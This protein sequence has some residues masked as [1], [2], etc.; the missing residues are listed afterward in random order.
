MASANGQD[1]GRAGR[2]P[3]V[4]A[5]GRRVPRAA[6]GDDAGPSADGGRHR[7]PRARRGGPGPVPRR[8][9]R[10]VGRGG[11]EEGGQVP[12]DRDDQR[13]GQRCGEPAEA[14]DG[15]WE[16]GAAVKAVCSK[17]PVKRK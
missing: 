13:L 3:R 12:L 5:G 1:G 2:A 10:G 8:P 7:Q 16:N 17:K 4:R 9:G 14:Q 11:V 6:P 15:F